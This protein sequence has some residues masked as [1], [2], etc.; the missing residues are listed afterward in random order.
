MF[1]AHLT[2]LYSTFF[3]P[4]SNF[5]V[6][7]SL[8][9]MAPCIE[10]LCSQR[11]YNVFFASFVFRLDVVLQTWH[12]LQGAAFFYFGGTNNIKC[13]RVSLSGVSPGD[14]HPPSL[15]VLSQV[16][17]FL[18]N[19]CRTISKWNWAK[20]VSYQFCRGTQHEHWLVDQPNETTSSLC[21]LVIMTTCLLTIHLITRLVPSFIT[22]LSPTS[23]SSSNCGIVIR[24]VPQALGFLICK[25]VN[26]PGLLYQLS[27]SL[28][29]IRAE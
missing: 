27:M 3:T 29:H 12:C 8:Q 16:L 10:L 20:L 26:N 17:T 19:S 11:S 23:N 1:I 24:S 28:V 4:F 25:Y 9:S 5:W 6:I 22:S 18:S 2:T 14:G 21:S 15:L 13:L 7:G